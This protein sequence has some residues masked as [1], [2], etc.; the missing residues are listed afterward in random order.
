MFVLKSGASA[1]EVLKGL[2][3]VHSLSVGRRAW[4][5]LT[6]RD[7]FDWRLHRGGVTLTTSGAGRNTRLAATP[8]HG[9]TLRARAPK[10]PAFASEIPPGP[11]QEIV[12]LLAGT[13]RLLHK[14][15]ARWLTLPA[16]VL[17]ED[18]KTVARIC[19][20]EGTALPADSGDPI[21]MPIRLEI[22]PIKGYTKEERSVR[23][24][25]RKNFDLEEEHRSEVA[26]VFAAL[27]VHPGDYTSSF[28]LELDP[29]L[30]A[31]EASRRVHEKLFGSMLANQE[32]LLA[33][34][35]ME[36]L[37]DFRVA[38]RRARSAASQLKDV[39]PP[40]AVE[41]LRRELRWLGRKTGPARDMDVYLFRIPGYR[42]SLPEGADKDLEP[43]VRLLREKKKKEL[44][45]LRRCLRS[46]R[47]RRLVKDWAVFIDGRKLG[48]DPGPEAHRPIAAVAS[49]R[50]WQA[51]EKVIRK[52]GDI[53]PQTPAKAL[54]RLRLDCKKLRYLISFFRSLYPAEELDSITQE[55]KSLQKHL[56]EF[57]DLQ[58]QQEA[59][60]RFAEELMETKRG[61][62]ATLLAMGQLLGQLEAAQAGER[63]MFHQHFSQFAR[64][65]NR[66]R[67][68]ALFGPRPSAPPDREEESA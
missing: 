48:E 11:L 55:L 5:T 19:F 47:H 3:E 65:A 25:I 20:R 39:F 13:R 30:S 22:I 67:F 51:F 53:G 38:I 49:E 31:I 37:H 15:K 42:E 60:R 14:G 59:L 41:D 34:W 43:L 64:P 21:E 2:G 24:F 44:G 52:G 61:P 17:N 32:G 16:A 4:E 33:D 46:A 12:H 66:K 18:E 57:N 6:Y 54:H 56:G 40:I 27:G 26:A 7:T 29:T 28:R 62:P 50:I 10:M 23:R 1:D 45:M 8:P 35:D 9:G 68:R 58:V 63:A 36:F